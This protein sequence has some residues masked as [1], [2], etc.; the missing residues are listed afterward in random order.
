MFETEVEITCRI[1]QTGAS[2]THYVVVP[3]CSDKSV[4]SM[5]GFARIYEIN[6]SKLYL[7]SDID[8]EILP[9]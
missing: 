6:M 7:N 3:I 8:E 5:F 1:L 2:Q 4:N 9:V